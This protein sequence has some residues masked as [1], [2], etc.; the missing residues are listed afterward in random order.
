[1]IKKQIM[2]NCLKSYSLGIVY[3]QINFLYSFLKF[4]FFKVKSYATK[5]IILMLKFK[6]KKIYLLKCASKICKKLNYINKYFILLYL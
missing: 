2:K 3:L 1:M 4:L 5:L 6:F